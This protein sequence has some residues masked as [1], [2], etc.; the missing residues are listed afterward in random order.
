M[1]AAARWHESQRPDSLFH[2]A[3]GY[4][5]AGSEGRAAPMGDWIMTPR[6]R[7]GD[8]FLVD[9]Y[10]SNGCRQLVLLGAGMDSRAYRIQGVDDLRVFEVDQWTT[11]DVKEPLLV[12]EKLSVKSRVAVG[13]E[14]SERGQWNFSD[15]RHWAQELIANGFD[16]GVPTVWLLEGLLMYL[17]LD[18]TRTMMDEIGRLS[19]P[20]SAVFHD[21]VSASYVSMN[22]VVGG[23]PFIGGSDDY[24]KLWAQH[25]GFAQSYVWNFNAVHVDRE[26]RMLYLDE[27]MPQATAQVCRGQ[28][29]V[30]FVEAQKPF[31][32]EQRQMFM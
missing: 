18:D 1:C 21:A 23:A 11:F 25:A 17:S 28:K 26:R 31:L 24:A 30:L 27:Q 16:P 10:T 20:G 19:A 7:F 4:K 14:F 12:G 3:L 6:T 8:D 22:I 9:K 29:L 13:A 2:D 5:L 15:R 32:P